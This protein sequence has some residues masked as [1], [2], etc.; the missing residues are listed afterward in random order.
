MM[1][2]RAI[3]AFPSRYQKEQLILYL[4]LN[5]VFS[6]FFYYLFVIGFLLRFVCVDGARTLAWK[7][8]VLA[9]NTLGGAVKNGTKL[10]KKLSRT[11]SI[12]IYIKQYKLFTFKIPSFINFDSKI[13]F[14]FLQKNRARTKKKATEVKKWQLQSGVNG[15]RKVELDDQDQRILNVISLD[16][17][18]GDGTSREA[19][20]CSFQTVCFSHID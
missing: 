2:K 3:G 15:S 14:L 9:L 1:P 5:N 17:V 4:K 20:R 10:K 7:L 12:L 16:A 19:G 11:W 6:Y 13:F 18:D 8:E